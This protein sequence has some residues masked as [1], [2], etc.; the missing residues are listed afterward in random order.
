MGV[1]ACILGCFTS[2]V[3]L[4][5]ITTDWRTNLTTSE[6]YSLAQNAL[7]RTL[8]KPRH[9]QKHNP[10]PLSLAAL[11][12]IK[13]I[14][15]ISNKDMPERATGNSTSVRL[16]KI[17]AL[18]LLNRKEEWKRRY[19]E[20]E[21]IFKNVSFRP[22]EMGDCHNNGDAHM[23]NL[24]IN[25][26]CTSSKTMVKVYK[27]CEPHLLS[28]L[29]DVY[30][31]AVS[32]DLPLVLYG[33]A[34]IGWYRNKKL[35]PYDLDLDAALPYNVLHSS[36]FRK[37][38]NRLAQLGYC[39]WFRTPWWLK[40]WSSVIAFDIFAWK[41]HQGKMFFH[42]GK[43]ATIDTRSFYDFSLFFPKR[44][45]M[46]EGFDVFVPNKPK[47][48]LDYYYGKGKWEK[49][50]NCSRVVDMKCIA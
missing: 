16:N 44:Q 50:I 40:I 10:F 7:P 38:L 4:L 14:P 32:G 29:R 35:I 49:P 13:N 48:Y 26:G 27:C 34:L 24:S 22:F 12:V 33:G 47:R 41:S 43:K 3:F 30:K 39:I 46:L 25:C 5:R 1:L 15:K 31:E 37:V 17:K 9:D 36:E 23:K 42:S 2:L 20:G 21:A 8:R 45:V 6:F 18:K 11:G 28:L 19:E